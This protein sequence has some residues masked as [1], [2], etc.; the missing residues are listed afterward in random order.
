M[1]AVGWTRF[2]KEN[3]LAA[4]LVALSDDL[5]RFHLKGGDRAGRD[6]LH[7]AVTRWPGWQRAPAPA[8]VHGRLVSLYHAPV[9]PVSALSLSRTSLDLRWEDEARAAV[10]ACLSQQTAALDALAS[11]PTSRLDLP[12]KRQPMLHQLQA[13]AAIGFLEGRVL[14][15][16]DMGLGK[17][18]TSLWATH[19]MGASR[20]LVVCPASVKF[21]WQRE[22]HE[23][24]L[25]TAFVID[26]PPKRRAS[27]FVDARLAMKEEPL[28]LVINYDLLLHLSA[29]QLEFLSKFV[30]G[31]ALICDESHYLK[32]R[33]AKR[34]RIVSSTLAPPAKF[35]LLLSGTPVRNMVDDLYSQIEILR[36]GTWTSYW[37]FSRRHLVMKAI[38]FGRGRPVEKIVGTKDLAGLNAVVNTLQVRR[39]KG[40]VLNLPPKVHTYPELTLEGDHLKVYRAMK[41][42]A[43]LALD[44]LDDDETI[45]APQARSAIIAALR[46]EQIAQG[47]CGGI[48]EPLVKGLGKTLSRKAQAIP[49]RP[50]EI[51]FPDS[52]KMIWLLETI[53][54]VLRQEGRVVVYSRF[55]APLFWLQAYQLAKGRRCAMLHGTLTSKA[56]A[57]VVELFQQGAYDVLL[58]QVKMA[59]G[60]NAHVAQ[61]ALFLGREWSPAINVQ[62]EDRLHRIGQ[63]GT[64]NVQIPIVRNTVE[65]LIHRKLMAKDADAEQALRAVTIKEF[66]EAL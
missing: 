11:K 51:V 58:V 62:A 13:I 21:N 64:V 41:E 22:I 31:Q 7:A 18:A 25:V 37:D 55:N 3:E 4:V 35:R 47:F 43:V 54:S 53:D 60:W 49:G 23:T 46:C 12:T 63:K 45:F 38:D 27:L 56:K 9:G 20:F 61:D 40:D 2:S 42:L 8:K 16:D 26:G 65:R 52:P 36:P 30:D 32:S 1:D 28:A 34:T 10:G 6:Q 14:L 5:T 44:E 29:G 19:F 48:P 24:L 33:K 15:A 39:K 50:R 17:T 66:K 57:E 59:E